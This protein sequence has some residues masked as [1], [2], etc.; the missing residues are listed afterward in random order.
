LHGS[1]ASP[2]PGDTVVLDRA[3]QERF[4]LFLAMSR[5]VIGLAQHGPT[6]VTIDD[7]HWADICSLDLFAYLISMIAERAQQM[8]LPLGVIAVHRPV[9]PG[10]RLARLLVRLERERICQSLDLQGLDEAELTALLGAL[11]VEHP[12]PQLL[13]TL[14]EIT[15]GNPLFTQEM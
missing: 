3:E 7:L 4:R 2:L 13:H 1:I 8:A 14:E 15:A 9:S 10:E 5:A 12:S 11:G 6:L